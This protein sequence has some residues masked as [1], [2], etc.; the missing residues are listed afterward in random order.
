MIAPIMADVKPPS[1]GLW[2]DRALTAAKS[3]PQNGKT[4][5]GGLSEPAQQ[6]DAMGPRADI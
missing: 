4:L 2:W 3:I 1:I 6:N 5:S